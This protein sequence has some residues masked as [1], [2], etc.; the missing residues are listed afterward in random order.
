MAEAATVDETLAEVD[1]LFGEALWQEAYARLLTAVGD[2]QDERAIARFK[3]ALVHGYN[4]EDFKRG[5]RHQQEKHELLDEVEAVAGEADDDLLLAAALHERGMALHIE[6]V[7]AEGDLDREIESFTRA[8]ELFSAA[9]DTESAAM[10][11]A[12]RGVFH[13]VA[14][15]D[16][17]TAWPLLLE[18]HSM[19]PSPDTS[20][21]R[22]EA[23]RHLGQIKQ[24]QGDIATGL[25]YLEESVRIREAV[26]KP[27]HLPSAY[28]V[29]GFARLE[30][31]DLDAAEADLDQAEKLARDLDMPLTVAMVA[32]NRADLDFARIA[33]SVWRRSHP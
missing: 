11:T 25:P 33:P 1:R 29:L 9:G 12:M 28:H 32:R 31:G 22:A 20:L 18:A 7:M 13:H 3:L 23:A 17:E 10:S 2:E 4:Q 8:A 6:F 19:A 21:A 27:L 14:R 26:G 15:L 24:E 5:L 30:D 16:R